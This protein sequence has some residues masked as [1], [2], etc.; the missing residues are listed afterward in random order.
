MPRRMSSWAQ[1][2]QPQPDWVEPAADA[3]AGAVGAHGERRPI[4]A[5][6]AADLLVGPRRRWPR[7]EAGSVASQLGRYHGRST[8]PRRR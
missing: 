2:A 4:P 6:A 8:R 5:V 7:L 1:S 3:A